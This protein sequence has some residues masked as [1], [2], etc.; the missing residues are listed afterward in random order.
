ML[1]KSKSQH[2]NIYVIC[3]G[4]IVLNEVGTKMLH[5]IVEHLKTPKENQ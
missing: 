4:F 1:K 2:H 3:T 5:F